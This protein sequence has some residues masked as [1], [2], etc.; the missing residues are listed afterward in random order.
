[1]NIYALQ[2]STEQECDGDGISLVIVQASNEAE[3]RAHVG[4]FAVGDNPWQDAQKSECTCL[5]Q[6]NKNKT[7]IIFSIYDYESF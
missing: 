4:R 5:G 6:N 3:A 2:C 1:M 7:E